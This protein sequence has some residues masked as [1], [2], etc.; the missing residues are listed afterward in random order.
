MRSPATFRLGR[1][2]AP[3]C[4]AQCTTERALEDA[5]PHRQRATREMLANSGAAGDLT[6]MRGTRKRVQDAWD[7]AHKHVDPPALR[8]FAAHVEARGA[9]RCRSAH[10]A[11]MQRQR[12]V[13]WEAEVAEVAAL[14]DW[15][16]AG[17]QS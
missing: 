1:G 7:F 10:A 2:C 15:G 17:T 12:R 6:V 16:S 9:A 13:A 4:T 14:S 5:L 3:P 11:G 8:R